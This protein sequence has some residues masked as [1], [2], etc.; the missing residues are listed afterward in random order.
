MDRAQVNVHLYRGWEN[1]YSG[2]IEVN[3]LGKPHFSPDHFM[4]RL[5]MIAPTG[6]WLHGNIMNRK[7]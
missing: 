3:Q 5:C 6:K 2:G 4:K 1:N 7:D